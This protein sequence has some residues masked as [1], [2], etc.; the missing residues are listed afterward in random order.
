[1]LV[2]GGKG[3]KNKKT[4]LIDLSKPFTHCVLPDFPFG[5]AGAIGFTSGEWPLVCGG[6]GSNGDSIKCFILKGFGSNYEWK[7]WINMTAPRT[8]ASA[9][10]ISFDQTLII[11]GG[12]VTTRSHSVDNLDNYKRYVNKNGLRKLNRRH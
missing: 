6:A 5:M 10:T 8:F 1:M 11:G 7:E 4:E 3:A 12:N 2:V 9:F